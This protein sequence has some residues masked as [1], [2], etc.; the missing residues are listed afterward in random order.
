MEKAKLTD[1]V[2]FTFHFQIRDAFQTC[3]EQERHLGYQYQ[4]WLSEVTWHKKQ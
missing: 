4:V 3:C 2:I 1:Y